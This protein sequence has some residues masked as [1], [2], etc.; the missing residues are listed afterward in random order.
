MYQKWDTLI[1]LIQDCFK[2]AGSFGNCV[3]D[4]SHGN[5]SNINEFVQFLHSGQLELKE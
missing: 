3:Y 2:I 1:F 5:R 4:Q